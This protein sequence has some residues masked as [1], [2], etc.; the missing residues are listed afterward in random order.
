V[1]MGNNPVSGVDPAGGWSAGTAMALTAGGGLMGYGIDR[2]AGGDGSVGLM[3]GLASGAV[4]GNLGYANDWNISVDGF[5]KIPSILPEKVST[6]AAVS[7]MSGVSRGIRL[8]QRSIEFDAPQ[9]D[10][11]DISMRPFGPSKIENY[12]MESA[13][14]YLNNN[15]KPTPV[16]R[17]AAFVREALNEG[18]GLKVQGAGS[19]KNY[20]PNLEKVG[21]REIQV[22]PTT[23]IPITGDIVIMEAT[24]KTVHGHAQ[25]YNG[26]KWVSDF[27]QSRFYPYKDRSIKPPFRVYR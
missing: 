10:N 3:I 12:D 5:E 15:A 6:S 11:Y 16:K 20:G 24:N 13:I 25:M 18:G 27:V 19:A 1:G 26:E 4:I 9:V 23:Y 8:G 14:E 22:D 7:M 17:C 21:F 2:L